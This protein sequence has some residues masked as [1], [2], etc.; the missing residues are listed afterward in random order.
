MLSIL[1][2]YF[3]ILY[4]LIQLVNFLKLFKKYSTSFKDLQ[5][6]FF[7]SL[8]SI[9]FFLEFRGPDLGGLGGGQGGFC[10]V[11]H[12]CSKYLVSLLAKNKLFIEKTP[13]LVYNLIIYNMKK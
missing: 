12:F 9:F 11:G 1:E 6:L 10:G 7:S 3:N 4:S 8:K 5:V 13:F 2:L